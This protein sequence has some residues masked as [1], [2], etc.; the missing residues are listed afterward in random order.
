MKYK[1]R[2]ERLSY[3]RDIA[4][5]SPQY[6]DPDRCA[7]SLAQFPRNIAHVLSLAYHIALQ[8]YSFLPIEAL[9]PE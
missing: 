3:Q 9:H 7:S 4:Q 2:T 1:N 5:E 8:R 6:L